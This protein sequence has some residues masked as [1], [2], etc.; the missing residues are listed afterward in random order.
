VRHGTFG[1]I[2]LRKNITSGRATFPFCRVYGSQIIQT[3]A[4]AVRWKN[5]L[6][7]ESLH[8]SE[9][10]TQTSIYIDHFKTFY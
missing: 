2:V 1:Q 8:G 9:P 3:N 7:V 5:R 10:G 6:L 4:E